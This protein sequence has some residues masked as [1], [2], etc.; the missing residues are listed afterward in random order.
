MLQILLLLGVGDAEVVVR[1]RALLVEV[2][3]IGGADGHDGGRTLSPLR[4]AYGVEAA[5]FCK[6]GRNRP[7]AGMQSP[8][9]G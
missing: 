9:M 8:M 7:A 6:L 4:L 2:G 3:R 5:H 1:V